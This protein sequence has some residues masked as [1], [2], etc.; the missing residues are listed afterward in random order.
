[1][2]QSEM[3]LAVLIEGQQKSISVDYFEIGPLAQEMSF[4][5]FFLFF[6]LALA[7]ILFSGA[8]R[9]EQIW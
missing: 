6:I 4:K 8:E 5:V 1:M 3:I 2:Q 9:F 7:S